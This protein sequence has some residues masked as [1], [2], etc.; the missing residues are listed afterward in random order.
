MREGIVDVE[1]GCRSKQVYLTRAHAKQVA[2][3]M[4]ARHRDAFHQYR[5]AG[6]GYWHVGHLV[7]AVIRARVVPR[8]ER[9][10]VQVA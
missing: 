6:C 5:C 2:R 7:P 8:W 10:S 9:L 3:L 1:R 4:G